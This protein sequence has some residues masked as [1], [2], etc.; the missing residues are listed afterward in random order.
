VGRL[1]LPRLVTRT[2]QG[3]ASSNADTL[4]W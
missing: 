3:D 2:R 4:G 1:A